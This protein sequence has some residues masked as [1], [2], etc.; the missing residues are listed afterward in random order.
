MTTGKRFAKRTNDHS[1]ERVLDTR[2]KALLNALCSEPRGR[3]L[4]GYLRAMG[5]RVA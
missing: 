5:K 3:A 1:D 4:E 2:A